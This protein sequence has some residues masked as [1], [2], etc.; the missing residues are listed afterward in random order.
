MNEIN[1]VL[2]F[3]EMYRITSEDAIPAMEVQLRLAIGYGQR[4][5]ELSIE[6]E[7][8]YRLKFAKCLEDLGQMEEETETTRKAKLEAWTA[9]E[10][11]AAQHLKNIYSTLKQIRMSLFQAI[12][13]RRT[14][15]Y[16]G[17]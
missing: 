3:I 4:V 16:G 7:K 6:A 17:T 13:T 2:G 5:G 10:K 14:E 12:K 11:A 8:T 15:P 1:E 9:D